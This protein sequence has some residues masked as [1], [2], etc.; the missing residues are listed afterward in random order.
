MRTRLGTMFGDTLRSL[1]KRP[2]TQQ[3][4]FVKLDAPKELRG[5]LVFENKGCTGCA[6]CVKDCPANALE[7]V[8]ND[9]KA[10]KF[11]FRYHAD[12]CTYCAQCVQSCRFSCLGM[13]HE[14]WELASVNKEP[15]TVY[16]GSDADVE[17]FLAA[18]HLAEAKEPAKA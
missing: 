3:Y 15:F 16:F 4:P 10:K 14:Q 18:H 5:A 11:V 7:I 1:F 2:I 9:K 17:T 13:S 12:R 6:L 8:V